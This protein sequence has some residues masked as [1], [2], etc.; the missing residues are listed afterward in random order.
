[1]MKTSQKNKLVW[2]GRPRR[3][4]YQFDFKSSPGW[5]NGMMKD[6]WLVTRVRS[7]DNPSSEIVAHRNM[8]FALQSRF[9][10]KL[11]AGLLRCLKSVAIPI[12]S[13]RSGRLSAGMRFS[14]EGWSGSQMFGSNMNLVL[15]ISE[16][17]KNDHEDI[18]L[19]E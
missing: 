19:P 7:H 10:Y 14:P 17:E 3:P 4:Y 8:V 15:R 1:M 9:Y 13:D 6:D 2:P 18:S 11:A 5:I 12:S 16:D